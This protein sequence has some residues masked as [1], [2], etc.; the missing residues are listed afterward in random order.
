MRNVNIPNIANAFLRQLLLRRFFPQF[1][2]V[3][4]FPVSLRPS[5]HL[6][7]I[8]CFVFSSSCTYFVMMLNYQIE[9]PNT[10]VAV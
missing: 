4:N 5:E 8:F 10:F 6:K 2:F 7:N 9:N 1:L 3:H